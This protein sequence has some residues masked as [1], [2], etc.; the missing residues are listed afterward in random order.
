V[1]LPGLEDHSEEDLKLQL[2]IAHDEQM[3]ELEKQ[4]ISNWA[5]MAELA[6]VVRD[7]CEAPL[8]GYESWT[9][10]LQFC[11]PQ[12]ASAI[13]QSIRII[14]QLPDIPREEIRE[15]PKSNAKVMTHM[16]AADRADPQ[17][18][19]NAKTMKPEKFVKEVQ[20]KRP[21]LHIEKLSPRKYGFSMSQSL[22]IDGAV[23]MYQI[24][25]QKP[26][27]SAEEA[28]EACASEYVLEHLDEYEKLTGK[29]F[30]GAKA[31]AKKKR[32]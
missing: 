17:W 11:A 18:K 16:D 14:E 3:K 30:P 26:E 1:S 28:L 4:N 29:T 8:L 22:M 9:D 13:H 19:K 27:A 6:I 12:S 32:R 7:N 25:E 5:A 21:G 24:I 31:R 10:W 23:E 2:A 20:K 15:M